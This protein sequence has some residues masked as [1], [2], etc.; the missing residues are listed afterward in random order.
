MDTQ[1]GHLLF[2]TQEERKTFLSSRQDEE[3]QGQ[4]GP[5]G[6]EEEDSIDQHDGSQQDYE[7]KEE[8]YKEREEFMA[9]LDAL[10]PK[11]LS[12]DKLH[13]YAVMSALAREKW[14]YCAHCSR[15]KPERTHHCRQCGICV[16]KMDHHCP[17]INNCVGQENYKL[18]LNM[19]LWA[20]ISLFHEDSL[21]YSNFY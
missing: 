2:E 16:L 3:F 10:Q 7:I 17:W 15:F 13:Q 12:T 18:F 19:L 20:G 6:E 14:R 1:E 9:K 4:G 5:N 21:I 8:D 11:Q